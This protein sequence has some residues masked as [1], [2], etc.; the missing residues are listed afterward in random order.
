MDI[1]IRFAAAKRERIFVEVLL[2]IKKIINTRIIN[3][4]HPLALD[5][6]WTG[7]LKFIENFEI[8]QMGLSEECKWKNPPAML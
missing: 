2:V 7:V 5:F 6:E 1:F 3:F 4:P 8:I